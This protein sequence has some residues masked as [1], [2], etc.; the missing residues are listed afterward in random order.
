[1]KTKTLWTSLILLLFVAALSFGQL[2]GVGEPNAEEIGV[3]SAQQDL[4]EISINKFEDAGFWYSNMSRDQGLTELRRLPGGPF[5]KQPIPGEEESGISEEDKYVLGLKV[6]YYRRGLN[7]FTLFPVRPMPVEGITK[8]LSVWVVGRNMSHMLS[9]I[10]SDYFG[11]RAEITMGK[12][13]FSGWK[14]LTVAVPPHIVQRDFHYGDRMGIKVL[15]FRVDTDPVE[16]FGTY[17]I[18]FD[19]LRAM[20]DLFAEN[21]RDPDDI[22]DVW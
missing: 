7:S 21:S 19:D 17:Y 6:S 16:S 20:T 3:D 4:K 18:Y 11:N 14:K 5:D 10:I 12:L 13:N 22:A 2:T 9:V 15:G 8:T 1:M